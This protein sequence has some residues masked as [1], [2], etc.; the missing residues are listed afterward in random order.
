MSDSIEFCMF[1]IN[2]GGDD[3]KLLGDL[4]P[5]PLGHSSEKAMSGVRL[6]LHLYIYESI[7]VKLHEIVYTLSVET[8]DSKGVA[9]TTT[10]I[11][12]W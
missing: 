4:C 12:P 6:S 8:W 10:W 2:I 1:L 7:F 3:P 9:A 5:C 11:C